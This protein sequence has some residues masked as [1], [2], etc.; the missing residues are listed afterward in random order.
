MNRLMLSGLVVAALA[1]LPST[2]LA[3]GGQYRGPG[4][5]VPPNPGGGG[6]RTPGPSGP[7]TPGPSG[8]TTPGPSGPSTPGPAGPTTGGPATPAGPAAGPKTPRGGDTGPDLTKWQFWWEFNKDPYLNLKDSVHATSTVT[9]SDEFFLGAS[10][11]ESTKD[12]L[13][14][15]DNDIVNNVLPALARALEGTTNRDITS[16]CIVAMAKIG[17]N[18]EGK[19]IKILDTFKKH[20]TSAE[21][22]IRETAAL[23]MGISQLAD[24]G[25]LKDLTD[26]V[27]DTPDG[28]KLVGRAEVDDRTRSFASYALGLIAFA[29]TDTATKSAVHDALRSQLADDKVSNRNNKVAAVNG[30][31]LLKLSAS[32]ADAAS[33]DEKQKKLLDDVVATLWG[34]YEKKLGKGEQLIQAHVPP[35]IAQLIGRGNSKAHQKFKDAFLKDLDLANETKPSESVTQS[36]A[37]A[38]GLLVDRSKEDEKYVEALAQYVPKGKDQMTKY[39]ALVALGEIGGEKCRAALLDFF[40]KGNKATIKPWSAIALGIQSFRAMKEAGQN[41]SIDVEV[42]R[43]LHATL[44]EVR[45]PESQEAIAIALGLMKYTDAA[46]DL[47]DMLVKGKSQE[48]LAGYLSIGL[49]LMNDTKSVEEIR[50]IVKSSIRRPDLLKQSAIALGKLGDKSITDVLQEMLTGGDMN[51]AKLSAVA[52]AYGFIGDRRT[53]DPLVKLL[54]DEKLTDLSRAFAAVALGGVADKEPLPWNSKIACD[55][56]YRAAVETLTNQSTGILDIL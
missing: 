11:T 45:N 42:G 56:N 6:A 31:R 3:H 32:G 37:I 21:Q 47:R 29:S 9:G 35:A 1:G 44:K 43:Q 41:A 19:N 36:C 17:K 20:L 12:T 54:F 38:L 24:K 30:L 15:S 8:P 10:K 2:G 50:S 49:A 14:P 5:V 4:D 28:R 53:I 16:S 27:M 22:E 39:F 48:E 13:K 18:N 34:Y 26:L 52:T 40:L 51:V 33:A 23:A 55:M 7:T 46:D 25:N